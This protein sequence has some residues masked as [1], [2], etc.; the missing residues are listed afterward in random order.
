MGNKKLK[1]EEL[2]KAVTVNIGKK[3]LTE[4][5]VNE[6]NAVLEKK[7]IVRVK[8]LKNFRTFA[9][10]EKTKKELVGEIASKIKG[11]LVEAKGFVLVFRRCK[12]DHSV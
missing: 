7:G 10:K 9:S 11:E 1:K 3:G 4:S 6:I 5:L 2:K 12:N 8:M